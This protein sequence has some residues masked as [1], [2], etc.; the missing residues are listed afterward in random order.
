M[1]WVPFSVLPRLSISLFYVERWCF[2]Y[3]VK[4]NVGED[5]IV[6][7]WLIEN[8]IRP[9]LSQILQKLEKKSLV[10]LENIIDQVGS[11]SVF[12]KVEGPFLYS[13]GADGKKNYSRSQ[14]NYGPAHASAD[15]LQSRKIINI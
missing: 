11:K 14:S 1:A 8:S 15:D 13:T 5:L 10:L 4:S 12:C 7:W 2:P 3:R 6:V 9:V